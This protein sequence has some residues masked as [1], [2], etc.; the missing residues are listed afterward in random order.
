MHMQLYISTCLLIFTSPFLLS[1]IH[2]VTWAVV[3]YLINWACVCVC[4]CVCMCVCVHVC[5]QVCVCVHV[6]VCVCV[7][8]FFVLK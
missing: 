7:C 2:T 5:V 4:V 1:Y 8:V 3:I 6:C